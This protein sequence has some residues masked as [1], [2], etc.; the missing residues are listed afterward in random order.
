LPQKIGTA[1]AG[2]RSVDTELM[3]E[4][5]GNRFQQSDIPIGDE[6]PHDWWIMHRLAA[7]LI[8]S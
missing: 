8:A 5:Q 2:A 6:D 7:D 1:L 4:C 3:Y